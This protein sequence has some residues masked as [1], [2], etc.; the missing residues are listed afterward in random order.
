MLTRKHIMEWVRT[1]L[2]DNPEVEGDDQE[3]V[4]VNTVAVPT[5]DLARLLVIDGTDRLFE[6]HIHERPI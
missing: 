4:P 1:H 3:M 6:I 2:A 5:G